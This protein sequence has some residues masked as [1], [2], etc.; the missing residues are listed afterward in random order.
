MKNERVRAGSL[1]S[2]TESPIPCNEFMNYPPEKIEKRR[3]SLDFLFGRRS[4]HGKLKIKNDKKSSISSENTPNPTNS[5][6]RRSSTRME[7]NSDLV[8]WCFI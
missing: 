1:A 7:N 2:P 3:L 6:R 8:A 4:S 5:E